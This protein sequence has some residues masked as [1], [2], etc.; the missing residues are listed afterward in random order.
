M[1]S[2]S[3]ASKLRLRRGEM[4]IYVTLLL[5]LLTSHA[6]M[7]VELDKC[8]Q[9]V[10]NGTWGQVGGFGNDGHP[11]ANISTAKAITYELCIKACGKGPE[12]F[13]W[14]TFSQQFSAWLLP[15]LALVSQLPFGSNDKLDNLLS[16]FLTVGSPTLATYSLALTVLNG[17]W[18]ARR[19]S[20]YTYPNTNLAVQI[21]SSLQQSPLKITTDSSLLASLVVLPENDAWWKELVVG[22]DY[23][24]TWSISAVSSIA[25]VVIAYV[26]TVID[27]FTRDITQ[28]INVNGEG[29]GSLWIWLVAIVI[30]W[31]QISPKCDARRVTQ[32]VERAN[33]M[34]YVA[35][36]T[37]GP[38]LA[39]ALSRQ[40]AISPVQGDED[41]LR[42][43]ETCTVPIYNYARFLPWVQA[44][45]EVSE[46]FRAASGRAHLHLP[47]NS[48]MDWAQEDRYV[49]GLHHRNRSGNRT[50]VENYCV[51]LGD[52]SLK[53]RSPW[54]PDVLSRVVIASAIALGLQWGTTGAAMIIVW[55]TPTTG[56]GCRSGAYILYGAASTVC[57]DATLAV[58]LSFTSR[59]DNPSR[60][61]QAL[62]MVKVCT[63]PLDRLSSLRK[64]PRNIER[65]LDYP[66]VPV[67]I[68]QLF[69]SMLL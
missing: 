24:H 69:Q 54:G 8:L 26:F 63:A 12:P 20:S 62:C 67:S 30:G 21:L 41:P 35:T 34:A 2:Y 25:W 13:Q 6:V 50:Q 53:R 39:S 38:V 36:P 52:T 17:R 4:R 14:T 55:F 10:R 42:H 51:P 45:E 22:L 65:R 57:L 1:S 3:S 58:Q 9:A 32:A 56:L 28:S 44:V 43:D 47:V 49:T 7:G 59:G 48:D 31:L 66:L 61:L 37:D 60:N 27:S 23:T 18:I 19:F 33:N 5:A 40:R 29:V 15:W 64:D 68:R 11:V 46:A 16:M